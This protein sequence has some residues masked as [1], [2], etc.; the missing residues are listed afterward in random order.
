[1]ESFERINDQEDNFYFEELVDVINREDNSVL[2]G[3]VISIRGPIIIVNIIKTNEEK[4]LNISDGLILKQWSPGKPFKIFNR[5]DVKEPETKKW[6]EGIITNIDEKNSIVEVRCIV[7]EKGIKKFWININSYSLARPGKYTNDHGVIYN[8]DE[9]NKKLFGKRKFRR[10]NEKQE[11]IFKKHMNENNL[12]IEKTEGDGNCLFRS[13]S[14]QIYG[15]EEYHEILREKCMDYIEEEKNYFQ[16]FIEGDIEEYIK[17]KR[18]P[19]VWGDDIEL[20]ALSEIYNR[21]IEIFSNSKEPLKTF[22]EN[23]SSFS[24]FKSNEEKSK[25]NSE[26]FPIRISYH[27]SSHYNSLIP[28]K[29]NYQ[30]SLFVNSLL[31]SQPG[32]FED[33]VIFKLKKSK[34]EKKINEINQIDK[35]RKIFEENTKGN[36]DLDDLL[37]FDLEEIEKMEKEKIA[38]N[39]KELKNAIEESELNKNEEDLLNTAIKLSLEGNTNQSKENL[40]TEE[41]LNIPAI[42][43]ALEF[44]FS[45]DDAVLAYSLYSDSTDLMLQYLYSMKNPQNNYI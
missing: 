26:N 16:Q 32:L 36:K 7:P 43:T 6:V 28:S 17:M 22:H 21:P 23:N 9:I 15:K 44:G 30:Y 39:N 8:P 13:I 38:Q 24:R 14:I 11:I 4:R 41:Y 18:V 1:M 31:N 5:V 10:M 2:E 20:Q 12:E 25:K 45:L 33:N 42:Q 27:G 40:G 19:G 3:K 37:V 29:T 34:T 35:S